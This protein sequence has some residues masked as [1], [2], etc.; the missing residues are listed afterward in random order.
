MHYEAD[1]KKNKVPE[2]FGN[3]LEEHY[4]DY[5]DDNGSVILGREANLKAF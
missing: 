5:F 2:N 3:L 4:Q 1:V